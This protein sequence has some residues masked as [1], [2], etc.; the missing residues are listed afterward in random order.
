MA[1][2]VWFVYFV[3][4]ILMAVIVV[5]GIPTGTFL[6]ILI[7]YSSFPKKTGENR[8]TKVG[9]SGITSHHRE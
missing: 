6:P 3:V 5:E 8:L 2:F 9:K 4:P 7:L 1:F